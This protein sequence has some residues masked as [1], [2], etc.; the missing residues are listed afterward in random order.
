[1]T[2]FQP[3]VIRATRVPM[4]ANDAGRDARQATSA[5]LLAFP[6]P[7]ARRTRRL[8]RSDEQRG[9]ILFF[10]GVRYERLAS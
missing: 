9:E 4:P 10:L 8:P 7:E 2:P 6:G 5:M 3:Q 1:M